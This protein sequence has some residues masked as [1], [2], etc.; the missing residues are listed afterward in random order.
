MLTAFEIASPLRNLPFAPERLMPPHGVGKGLSGER[1]RAAGAAMAAGRAAALAGRL[2]FVC[3]D[4]MGPDTRLQ[5]RRHRRQYADHAGPRL[6]GRPGLVRPQAISPQ[7]ALWR[8][9]PLVAAGRPAARRA[10][11]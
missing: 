5:P 10:E 8:R 9:H 2:R 1:G 4:S 11:A 6:A 3:R 7:S